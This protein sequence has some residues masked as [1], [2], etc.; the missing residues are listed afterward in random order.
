MEMGKEGSV[1]FILFAA[2]SLR[3]MSFPIRPFTKQR[4]TLGSRHLV[5][6]AASSLISAQWSDAV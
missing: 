3:L 2:I 1:P 4:L 5:W 6:L